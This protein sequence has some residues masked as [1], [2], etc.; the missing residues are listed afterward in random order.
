[1]KQALNKL[2]LEGH[3]VVSDDDLA[4]VQDELPNHLELTQQEAGCLVF[5]VSPD[6]ENRNVFNV[7]E[8]FVDRDAFDLHQRRVKSSR[9][10]EVSAKVE[11]H[12]EI[13]EY[14]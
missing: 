1:M 6:P 11:R 5:R 8:E 12:Y 13:S 14:S 2:I 7:Y 10:G 9:W 3:I 4:S